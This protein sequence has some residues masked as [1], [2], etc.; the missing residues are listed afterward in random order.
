MKKLI[1]LCTSL[2]LVTG[3]NFMNDDFKDKYVYTT[4][5][6]IEYTTNILYGDYATISSVYPNGANIDYEITSKKK[7]QY[8][9]AETFVYSGVAGEASLARDILNLNNKINLIDAT[10]GITEDSKLASTW[11]DPSNYLKLSNNIKSKLIEYN[12]NIYVKESIEEKYKE[13]N[14]KISEL[15]V[16]LY[17]IGK[18]GNY[19]TILTTNSVFNFLTKYNINVISLDP[20]NEAIDKA[21]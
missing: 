6:P 9:N 21:Y 4:F 5:Y 1:I 13:L 7:E 2:F 3:C 19:N 12:N 10:K 18:N 20:T 16:Q 15:D 17:D 11:I 8:S 14:E